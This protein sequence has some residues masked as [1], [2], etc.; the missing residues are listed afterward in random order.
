MNKK[1]ADRPLQ[2][3]LPN[4]DIIHSSHIAELDLPLLPVA[5]REVHILPGLTSHSLVSVVKLCNAGCQVDVK[6]ISCE[7]RYRG[8]TIV[9][10]SKDV[11]TG[12][13]MMPLTSRIEAPTYETSRNGEG[14]IADERKISTTSEAGWENFTRQLEKVKNDQYGGTTINEPLLHQNHYNNKP[15]YIGTPSAYEKR[16]IFDINS[17]TTINGPRYGNQW[18]NSCCA[19]SEERA[20]QL[21]YKQ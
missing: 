18:R 16:K 1:V 5:G 20:Q 4:G 8:K 19:R 14:Q 9:Q 21:L 3:K 10:C 12:L 6:D 11:N 15:K 2:V 7:I 13:W 17:S